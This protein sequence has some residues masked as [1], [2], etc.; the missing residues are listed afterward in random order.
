MAEQPVSSSRALSGRQS[1]CDALDGLVAQVRVGGSAAMVLRGEAGVGKTALLDYAVAAAGDLRV[2]RVAGVESE[3]ELPFAALHQMCAPLLDCLGRLPDPQRD[4]LGT[5]FGLRAGPAP[6]HFLTGLAVL[7]L[8]AE[9][10]ADR[11]LAC[12]IDDAQWLDRASAQV[13]AFAARRLLAESVLV[14]LATREPDRDLHGLPELVVEGVPRGNRAARPHPRRIELAR[15]QLVYGEW[16]RRENRRV[17]ARAQLR[18]AHEMFVSMRA[19]GF[20]ER[21]RCE[22]LATGETARK[23]TVDT[24]DELTAQER[25][26]ACRARDGY[27]NSEIGA[28]LFLSPRTVEWHLRRVFTKLGISSRRQLRA[29]LPDSGHVAPCS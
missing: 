19:D 4:A 5:A 3:M 17:D 6:D 1:E 16:L 27:S 29:A 25:Q 10:A 18:T 26:V 2:V 28:E 23:R 12:V 15:A 14:I 8:L 7:S 20:A 22:L 11:P 21:A 9:A 13:L 24:C